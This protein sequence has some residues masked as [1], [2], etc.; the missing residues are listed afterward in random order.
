MQ[1]K[2][3]DKAEKHNN[4][5]KTGS[6]LSAMFKKYN[7][8]RVTIDGIKNFFGLVFYKTG[9]EIEVTA[10]KMWDKVAH[11]IGV[12]SDMT[13]SAFKAI[14]DFLD[15][16]TDTILDDLGEPLDR[17]GSAFAGISAIVKETKEDKSRKT[18]KEVRR[19]VKE[20]F[21]KH[22]ELARTLYKY[23]APVA[24]AAVFFLVVS[25][26]LS[27]E[28]AIQ[29]MLDDEPIGVIENYTV[30]TNA[31]KIITNKLVSTNEQTWNLDSSIKMVPLGR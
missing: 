3:K 14:A 31:D 15:K 25:I 11:F 7:P 10:L 28:Y 1:F 16:L 5:R 29:V 17:V 19:Y 23:A 22:K 20:G 21:S 4:S 30:L 18:G 12:V 8:D 13:M 2:S 26:T 27:K 24:A 6:V 9:Y